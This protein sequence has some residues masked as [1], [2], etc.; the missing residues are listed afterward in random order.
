M[1]PN[2]DEVPKIVAKIFTKYVIIIS[3]YLFF[4][5]LATGNSFRSLAFSFRMGEKTVRNI[6]Y[7]TCM[8]IWNKM[9]PKPPTEQEWKEI[10]NKFW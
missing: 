6:I 10:A 5:F 9:Q 2:R 8:A 4:R 7:E 1:I 3:I